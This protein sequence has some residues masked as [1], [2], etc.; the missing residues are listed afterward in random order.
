[1]K[2]VYEL[3]E[4]ISQTSSTVLILG[5][6]GVGKELVAHAI[7][8]NSSRQNKP[9]IKFSCAA[10]PESTIESELF[11]H[12]KGSFTGAFNKHIGRFEMA[13]GGTIFLDE[14]GEL[15]PSVQTK[16]LR[17]LQEKEFERVGGTKTL[18]ADIR[19]IPTNSTGIL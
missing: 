7:H 3:I 13:E 18:K 1:M 19:I 17:V 16:L 5:E 4:K 12:E 2:H 11:G 6:S 14:I 15:T 10:L 9:F 8:Y